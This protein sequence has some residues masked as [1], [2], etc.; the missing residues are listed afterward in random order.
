MTESVFV[1]KQKTVSE[2]GNKIELYYFTVTNHGLPN[3][4]GKITYGV[5]VEMY[6][7]L[8]DGQVI[9]E[10]QIIENLFDKITDAERFLDIIQGG[11]VTPVSLIDVTEDYIKRQSESTL[12]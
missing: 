3:E 5:G 6:T 1:R 7:Q 11:C 4:F 10:R 12:C 9:K 2:S 8:S